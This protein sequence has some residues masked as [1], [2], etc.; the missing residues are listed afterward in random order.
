MSAKKQLKFT[1][2]AFQNIAAAENFISKENPVAAQKVVESIYKTA[3]KL[4]TYSEL[5]KPGRLAGTRELVL[6]KY[7]F[8]II[9]RVRATQV[10]VY[11][12]L[13]QSRRYF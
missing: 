11:S 8:I 10:V 12:V 5:G 9:Y 7:P 4:E 3:E 6:S 13:H 2:R 1:A